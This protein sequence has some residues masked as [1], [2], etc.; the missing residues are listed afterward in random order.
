MKT[1]VIS[2]ELRTKMN[3]ICSNYPV[4]RAAL[5][6]V[7]RL[8]QEANRYVSEPAELEVAEYFEIPP[9]DVREVMTFYTLFYSKP[10]GKCHVQLCRTLTCHL[11]GADELQTHLEQRLGV[12]SGETTKDGMFSLDSVECL[13]AC[14]IAPT[15]KINQD[16]VGPLT[17]EKLDQIL[18]SK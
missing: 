14:E 10:K 17:H 1:S 15:A 7:L 18:D 2:S 16:F 5:L 13:G 4:K 11:R 12:K 9:A 3:Q 6:P 8:I